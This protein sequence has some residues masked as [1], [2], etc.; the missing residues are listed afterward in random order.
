MANVSVEPGFEQQL[1]CE[2]NGAL[3]NSDKVMIKVDFII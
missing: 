1:F 3:Q 2:K